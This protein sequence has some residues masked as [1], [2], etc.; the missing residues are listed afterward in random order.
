MVNYEWLMVN[1]EGHEVHQFLFK[2]LIS[3]IIH[4]S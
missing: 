3:F 2:Q 1:G 4:N